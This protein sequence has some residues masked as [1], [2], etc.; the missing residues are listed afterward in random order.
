M[1]DLTFIED[2]NST[3]LDD[4]IVNFE[5]VRMVH[6]IL[7]DIHQI[8]RSG[9]YNFE[10]IDAVGSYLSYHLIHLDESEIYKRSKNCELHSAPSPDIHTALKKKSK[11]FGNLFEYSNSKKEEQRKEI[12]AE[13]QQLEGKESAHR[14]L[15]P[16][17]KPLMRS[18]NQSSFLMACGTGVLV[19]NDH[20]P[21]NR[22]S[23]SFGTPLASLL[24]QQLQAEEANYKLE[25]NAVTETLDLASSP[26]EKLQNKSKSF[27]S[28]MM[29]FNS[30][31][32][33]TQSSGNKSI[34]IEITPPQRN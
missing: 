22:A 2:G 4:N 32:S 14:L 9:G 16:E 34:S 6:V 12:P 13:Q 7:S 18:M 3:Y 33:R 15:P 31:L 30:K 8:Q 25:Q 21:N 27:G 19:S 24:Q 10:K 26:K 11:S 5:R 17:M 20:Q 28:M 1:K 23:V 29:V